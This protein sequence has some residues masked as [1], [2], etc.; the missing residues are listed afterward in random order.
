[1]MLLITTPSCLDYPFPA[2]QDSPTII[3]LQVH[4]SPV[5]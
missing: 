3:V 1:M 5:P 4:N 2:P